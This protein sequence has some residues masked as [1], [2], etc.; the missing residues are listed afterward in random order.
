M[1]QQS[2]SRSILRGSLLEES[3]PDVMRK[4]YTARLTGELLLINE[5]TRRRVFFEM[6]RAIFASSNRKGDRLGEFMLRRGEISQTTFELATSSLTRDRRFGRTLVDMG[7]I[8]E[9][10]LS[11]SVHEQILSII[12]SLFEWTTGEFE[13]LE[14][15]ATNVPVDLRL[16]LSMAD[17][18][19]EGVRRIRDFAVVRRGL[20][21][22][23]RLIAPATDPLLRLQRASLKPQEQE[24]FKQI[25][26]PTDLLSLIVFSQQPAAVTVRA[27]YGLVSAGFF[28]YLPPPQVSQDTG[29][30]TVT[31]VEENAEPAP[32]PTLGA[33]RELSLNQDLAEE[34]LRRE[35]E[36]LR[37][38]LSADDPFTVLGVSNTAGIES[39]RNAY[40]DLS[41]RF[42]PDRFRQASQELRQEVEQIFRHLTEAYHRA[43]QHMQHS[44]GVISAISGVV[45]GAVDVGAGTSVEPPLDE[46][47]QRLL[48]EAEQAYTA[49]INHLVASRY[50]DAVEALS[51]ATRT[52]PQNA[53]YHASLALALSKSAERYREAEQHFLQAI[54]LDPNN[55]QHHALLGSLYTRLG[56]ARRAEAVYRQALKL[57]P[58]NAVA[59]KGLAA[60]RIDDSLLTR[61][62]TRK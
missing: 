11:K 51:K 13:F 34:I 54:E 38:R 56:M 7:I 55:A 15:P 40:Y 20:G 45:A 28:T 33:T 30:M 61:L 10:Q 1:S 19:L 41:R 60:Q 32:P 21:D 9:Q 22:L 58:Q 53:K 17:I 39:L 5:V 43:R 47:Q 37:A 14:R 44:A 27:L 23:N 49:G 25:T 16:N 6:G 36:D 3:L 59:L 46:A 2:R 8:T 4:I 42:H 57:D 24:V 18:I 62:F 26:E 12:Y 29:F 35:I 31:V 50:Q 48:A 52:A